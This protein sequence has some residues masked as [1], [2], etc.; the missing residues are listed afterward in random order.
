MATITAT[1]S[2]TLDGVMQAPAGADEDRRGGFAHG[3]WALPFASDEQMAI[4]GE[5]MGE[6]AGMLFGRRTYDQLVGHW[7]SAPEPNPFGGFIRSIPKW[8]ASRADAPVAHPASTLL[9]G[10]AAETV[11]RLREEVGGP[12]S[13]LG[14]G[15][16]V[17]SL[18]AAGLL[19]GY[20]L[21]VHPIVLGSGIR[22]FGE[23]ER[24]DLELRRVDRTSTG[25]VI[26]QLTVRR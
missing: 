8:V 1:E 11:A 13:V 14:S 12:I 16:L 7:L 15:E 17:R 3:G 23:G 21:L 26:Q 5:G 20:V 18:H 25:V 6:T 10:D 2:I 9:H 24:R 19:D 4:M 22:L